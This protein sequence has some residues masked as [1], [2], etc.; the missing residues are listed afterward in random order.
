MIGRWLSF[1]AII[2]F[3]VTANA[4]WRGQPQ[5][6]AVLDPKTRDWVQGLK[7]EH[8]GPCCDTADGFRL[9]EFPDPDSFKRRTRKI[10]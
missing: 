10:L 6:L 4:V 7:N 9:P 3:A 8:G 2:L 5:S 1:T